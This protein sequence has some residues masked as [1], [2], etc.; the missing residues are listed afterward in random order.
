MKT[1]KEKFNDLIFWAIAI[2]GTLI[3]IAV[4]LSCSKPEQLEI[5]TVKQG[6]HHC[7]NR[8]LVFEKTYLKFDFTIDQSWYWKDGLSKSKVYG[9]AFGTEINSP[10]HNSVRL[11]TAV[12]GK[13]IH[14]YMF[15]H[16]DKS[17]PICHDWGVYEMGTYFCELGYNWESDF[18]YM[19]MDGKTI[20]FDTH[21]IDGQ[22]IL[23][24]PYIGGDYTIGHDWTVKIERH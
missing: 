8:G 16:I 6:K 3:I 9:L 13:D 22:S 4:S 19:T 5:Y 2:L 11:A 15:C 24:Y 20:K 23:C 12:R 10:K 1:E 18:F 7:A 21:H 17:D 14:L